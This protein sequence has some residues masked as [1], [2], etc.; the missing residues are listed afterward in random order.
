LTVAAANDPG[1]AAAGGV[2]RLRWQA[3]AQAPAQSSPARPRWIPPGREPG[4]ALPGGLLIQAG[5]FKSKDNADKAK[6]LLGGIAQVEVAPTQVGG[7]TIFRVRVGPFADQGAASAAL[8]RV[9]GA[10]YTG[11]RI[12]TN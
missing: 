2:A 8:T 12:I 11:A 5:S 6:S 1:E 4:D 10:G 7:E 3:S 9:T